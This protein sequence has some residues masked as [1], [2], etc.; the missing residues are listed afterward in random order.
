MKYSYSC[1]RITEIPFKPFPITVIIITIKSSSTWDTIPF[2]IIHH[3]D[4]IYEISVFYF[5]FRRWKSNYTADISSC[6]FWKVS[7][8]TETQ[9]TNPFVLSPFWPIDSCAGVALVW[10]R[11][12]FRF[13]WEVEGRVWTPPKPCLGDSGG[14]EAVHRAGTSMPQWTHL[15]WVQKALITRGKAQ[16]MQILKTRKD[17][18]VNVVVSFTASHRLSFYSWKQIYL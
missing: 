6:H 16:R 9:P 4:K 11:L 12:D 5:Q 8:N 15:H 14:R 3:N 18:P 10:F 2:I 17:C 1:I 13:G 7:Y